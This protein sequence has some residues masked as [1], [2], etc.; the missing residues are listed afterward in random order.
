MPEVPARGPLWN[1]DPEED[2]LRDACGVF[3]VLGNEDASI[4]T[5]LGLHAL[6]HRG[7]EGCGIAAFDGEHFHTERHLGLV[8]DHFAGES[9]RQRLPGFAAIGH[10]RYATQGGTI[11][12]NVQP[13]FAD[14]PTGGFA[15]GHNGNLT[16]AR[17]LRH[18][19]VRDGAIFQSTSDTEVILQLMARS[20]RRTVVDR[21]VDA[22]QQISGAYALVCLT[23]GMVIGARDPLGIRP[24]VLG[25]LDG[26]PI[27]ASE[28]CA[29]DIIG[30][31]FVRQI[32]NGEVVVIRRGLDGRATIES[33]TPFAAIPPRPC[34]FEYV[35][36]ARPDSII[37]GRSVYDVRKRLGERL[38]IEQPALGADMVVPVPDSGVPAALGYAAAAAI[39]YELGIIR[40][41][42]VG[43]TFIQPKQEIRQFK[44]RMKHSANRMVLQDKSVVLVDDSI[45][46]GTTSEQIVRMVREAGAREVHF[47]V[48]CPPIKHAD[49]YGIDMPSER[50]LIAATMSLSEMAKRLGAD[51]V[52]FLSVEGMYWALGE[53][54][55]NAHTPQYSDHCFTGDYPT[56]LED[57]DSDR[58]SKDFQLSLLAEVS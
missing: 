9:V 38:A 56:E 47:R 3:A 43:R 25:D 48:A 29:L 18:D 13:L 50:E 5:A 22:L 17:A 35:Y 19:L 51:S 1:Y 34:V 32:G 20:R 8:G 2:R 57:R 54:E 28:T 40:N 49:F 39:P 14:L 7:Q 24:L 45:V 10:T 46:R 16:N 30:A 26:A 53:R 36:F 44:V 11:L 23:D 6:Q 31:R 15:I 4:L 21:F 42:Y 52:G 37:D 27:L 55:R 12:R 58:A 41:H 33:K